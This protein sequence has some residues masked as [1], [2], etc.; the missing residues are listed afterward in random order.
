MG[1][2][3]LTPLP[4]GLRKRDRGWILDQTISGVRHRTS[5][6]RCSKMTAIARFN[7]RLIILHAERGPLNNTHNAPEMEWERFVSSGNWLRQLY[8]RF[9]GKAKSR[10][11]DFLLSMEQLHD[12][13]I[14]SG[15][16]CQLTGVPFAFTR[17]LGRRIAPY[18]PSIDR[19]DSNG[20]YAQ[21]NCRLV[22]AAA[23][24]ALSDH[25]DS[26]FHALAVGYVARTMEIHGTLCRDKSI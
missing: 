19:I 3:D 26:V 21:T 4:R 13:A 16:R 18:Q 1:I 6:G 11:I 24:A 17:P 2:T 15:G 9:K 20:P 8:R 23:N 22:C 25:G 10:G 7:A 14:D 12:I 5:L